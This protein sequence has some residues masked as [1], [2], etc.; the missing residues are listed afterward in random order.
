ILFVCIIVYFFSYIVLHSHFLS[1][2]TRRSS[3]LTVNGN[4][5][6]YSNNNL[7][8]LNALNSLT[9]ITQGLSI[10]NN[11]SLQNLN[12]LTALSNIVGRSEEH[13]S[14]LQSRENLVCRLLL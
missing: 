3:D 8:H 12:G 4:L 14:E 6:I 1:F 10:R 11:N 13:T 2:P 7:Q 9:T 5:S